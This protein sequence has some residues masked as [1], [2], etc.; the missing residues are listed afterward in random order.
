M[1]FRIAPALCKAGWFSAQEVRELTHAAEPDLQFS[2]EQIEKM[3]QDDAW[4]LE[5]PDEWPSTIFDLK[6]ESGIDHAGK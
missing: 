2:V 3:C 5:L 4:M 1:Y 6:H